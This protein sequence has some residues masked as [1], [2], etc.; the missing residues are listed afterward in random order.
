MSCGQEP[1][2]WLVTAPYN[3][4]SGIGRVLVYGHACRASKA[5]ALWVAIP[6]AIIRDL[7]SI[8]LDLYRFGLT[9][10]DPPTVAEFFSLPADWVAAAHAAL[11][12]SSLG[13]R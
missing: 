2:T 13:D 12:E 11:S 5:Q 8:V 9:E 4:Q 6:L 10:S 1:A 7:P 3:G